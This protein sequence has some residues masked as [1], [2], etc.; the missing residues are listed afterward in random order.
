MQAVLPVFSQER[1]LLPKQSHKL[2]TIDTPATGGGH[3][4]GA[5]VADHACHSLPGAMVGCRERLAL[6]AVCR[7]WLCAPGMVECRHPQLPEHH[8]RLVLLV[9]LHAHVS[10]REC[11]ASALPG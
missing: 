10:V 1:T 8:E 3:W 9:L 2:L 7:G 11:Q 5:R 6:R 4:R